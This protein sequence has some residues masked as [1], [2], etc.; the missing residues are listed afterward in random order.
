[1]PYIT[2]K[3]RPANDAEYIRWQEARNFLETWVV[4]FLNR[5]AIYWVENEGDWDN[6]IILS[7][8]APPIQKCLILTGEHIQSASVAE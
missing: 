1:M 8:P 4:Y 3:A 6:Y 2:Y 5:I 7:L